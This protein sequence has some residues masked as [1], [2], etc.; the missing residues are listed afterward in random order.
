MYIKE[1]PGGKFQLTV[2]C[3]RLFPG[4]F[5]YTFDSLK[6][7]ARYEAGLKTMFARN[8]VPDGLF[9]NTREGQR[10]R[11]L[12]EQKRR[13]VR[14]IIRAYIGT[15]N[16]AQS[17]EAVLGLLQDEFGERDVQTLNYV[18]AEAWVSSMKLEKNYAPGTIRKRLGSMKRALDWWIRVGGPAEADLPGWSNPLSLLPRGAAT[19]N[20]SDAAR[21][22][23]LGGA[24]KSDAARERR[25]SQEEFVRVWTV[26][27]G[28]P[29]REGG[30]V[31]SYHHIEAMRGLFVLI[32]FTGLRLRE[33][34][35]LTVGQIDMEGRLIHVNTSKQWHGRKATRDVPIRAKLVKPL[36]DYLASLRGAMSKTP[37]FP[38]WHPDMTVA[39]MQR[40]TNHLSQQFARVFRFAEVLDMREH[41]L[42][43]EATCQWF[44]IRNSAGNWLFREREIQRIMGWTP[45]SQMIARY[46][47]FRGAD[48]VDRL[49]EEV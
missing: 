12:A 6:E 25:M 29:C 14:H 10:K 33:A 9:E 20:R 24:A 2:Q 21:V 43:H 22:E 26:L 13:F 4:R 37:V 11:E 49:D 45:G 47:S 41:D 35:T 18:W 17:D 46:A 23:K 19:Y 15:G 30:K 31:Y 3:K 28:Q 27:H 16:V 40:V 48:M 32:Y 7:A 34:F 38:W 8:I 44:E 42:R 1:V 36:S 39:Q 5:Y